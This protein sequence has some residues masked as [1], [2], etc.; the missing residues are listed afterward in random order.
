MNY[1]ISFYEEK[2]RSEW[3][4]FARNAANGTFFHFQKFL[5][6]HPEGRFDHRHLIFRRKGHI[7]AIWPGAYRDEDGLKAWTSH[8]GASYGG[9]V[10]SASNSIRDTHHLVSDLIE[11]ARSE[12]IERL[13]CT[14]PPLMNHRHPADTVEFAMRRAGFR[15][16]KQ[17]FTQAVDLSL[18]P[19]DDSD[20]IERYDNK[21]RTAIRKARRE[22]VE[23]KLHVPLVGDTL[24]VF[25]DIL[26]NN[27]KRLGVTPTHTEAELEKLA[28]LAPKYLDLTMAYYKGEAIAGIL[29]F[30]CNEKVILEFYIAHRHDAQELRPVP[31]LVHETIILAMRRGFRWLDFGTSTEGTNRVTWGL[32]AFKENFAVQGFFRNTLVLDG[33]QEW[34]TPEGFLPLSTRIRTDV[35]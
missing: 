28:E 13:R 23:V 3:E 25:Y 4:R 35:R 24:S 15:Y 10:T 14:P 11:T 26:Y 18:L 21:T 8:P 34:K 32:A 17:D 20:V 22:G 2:D 5:D 27:R 19:V 30:I 31:L 33:I 29:N 1:D 16:M 9:L 6:Y 7:V 12:G